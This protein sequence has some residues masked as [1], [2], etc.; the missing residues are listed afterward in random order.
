MR[1]VGKRGLLLH[2]EEKDFRKER[3]VYQTR[4]HQWEREAG[5]VSKQKSPFRK[6]A[7]R[8]RK[9]EEKR[10]LK[11][12][13][14]KDYYRGVTKVW[15]VGVGDVASQL[16]SIGTIFLQ[17]IQRKAGLGGMQIRGER[18]GGEPLDRD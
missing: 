14:D 16:L 10:G 3:K 17:C 13:F 6:L 1:L 9:S 2:Q 11:N 12:Q 15:S 7:G 5:S 8:G 4:L 18:E